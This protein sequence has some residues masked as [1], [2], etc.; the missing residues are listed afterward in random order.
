MSLG[1]IIYFID[2]LLTNYI[3]N[4]VIKWL[5]LIPII[6]LFSFRQMNFTKIR[7]L[8]TENKETWWRADLI[9]N[10]NVYK[11]IEKDLPENCVIFN[12]R[13]DEHNHA[14]G[15]FIEGMFYTGH[16]CYSFPPSQEAVNILKAKN[17]PIAIFT[18]HPIPDY[19]QNDTSIIKIDRILK[20][21][22]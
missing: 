15:M 10:K 4:K 19:I 1:A 9:Y 13:G 11:Q 2:N 21:D 22:M 3:S 8:H 18:H 16:D 17:Y 14:N 20:N 7:N 6:I 5:I 12:V